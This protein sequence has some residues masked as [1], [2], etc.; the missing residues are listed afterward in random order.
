MKLATFLTGLLC[1]HALFSQHN[2]EFYNDGAVVTV[3]AG[4]EVYVMG[5]FH[6]YQVSGLLRNNGFIEIQGYALSDNLFQQRGTGT[7]LFINNDVNVGQTQYISGSYAVRGGQA[8]IGVDDGSFYNLEL[9]NDQGIVWL[10]GTGNIADVRNSVDFNGPNA[11]VVN[12]IITH[13]PLAIPANGSGYLA[14]FGLMN[15]AAGIGNLIDNTVSTGGNMSGTDNGYIQGNFRRAIS[16]VGGTYNYVLGL[17]PAGAAAQR[18]MQYMNLILGANNYDVISGYFQTGLDNTFPAGTECSGYI[19]DYWGGVDHGQWVMS[20][21]TGAG[22]GTFEVRVWPQDDNFPPKSVWLVTKNNTVLGT[23]DD[24]G[25]TPIGLDRAGYNGMG[26]F[27]VAASEILLP[28][29]LLNIWADP[30]NDHIEVGW[31]VGSELNLDFYEVQRSENGIDFETIGIVNAVGSTQTEQ[32]YTFEDYN[33]GRN[34]DYYYRYQ[35]VDFDMYT[36]YSPIVNARLIG[37]ENFVESILVYPNPTNGNLFLELILE[38]NSLVEMKVL[39]SAGQQ[40]ESIERVG[41]G[42]N[43]V[44]A[45]NTNDWAAG[46]YVV[47]VTDLRTGQTVYRK[48][49]KD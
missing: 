29:E 4:A 36:E 30:N 5:D 45:L 17:Q 43:N 40:I 48:V 13:D 7:A 16:P 39:N 3:Q 44:F 46:I 42:G 1:A 9:S 34:Q 35:S 31:T 11:P 28:A 27:G 14:T 2:N 23:A 33:V 15:P 21:F 25:P 49:I 19:I 10:N 41:S 22:A 6:N 32:N 20:D 12:R 38:L 24:C 26:Q 8:A 47:Q 37:S 18:G